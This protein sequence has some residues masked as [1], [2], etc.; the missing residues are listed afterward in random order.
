MGTGSNVGLLLLQAPAGSE[1]TDRDG[2]AVIGRVEDFDC[3][4]EEAVVDEKV[5]PQRR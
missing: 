3:V 5:F 2:V 4:D 1:E